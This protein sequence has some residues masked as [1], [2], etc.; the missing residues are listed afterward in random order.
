MNMKLFIDLVI[1][2]GY[3]IY[4]KS[5]IE[6]MAKQAG[7]SVTASGININGNVGTAARKFFE[8]YSKIT[9]IA[10]I[11]LKMMAKMYNIKLQRVVN[12]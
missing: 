4:G 9:P 12:N 11:N 2:R 1:R 8:V 6:E 10:A 5:I 3:G 7:I